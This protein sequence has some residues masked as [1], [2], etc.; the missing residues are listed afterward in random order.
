LNIQK[1]E[2]CVKGILAQDLG[3]VCG[4]FQGEFGGRG[5][6]GALLT[7]GRGSTGGFE[8]QPGTPVASAP[9]SPSFLTTAGKHPRG[10]QGPDKGDRR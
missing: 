3:F 10:S 7:I 6:G 9:Y 8:A 2:L 5:G 4:P 1:R